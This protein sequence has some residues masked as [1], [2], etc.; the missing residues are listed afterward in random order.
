MAEARRRALEH[1]G[2]SSSTRSSSSARSSC[3]RSS[4]RRPR[5]ARRSGRVAPRTSGRVRADRRA[6]ACRGVADRR[7]P[8]AAVGA[9]ARSSGSRLLALGVARTASRARRRSSRFADRGRRCAARGAR[10]ACGR[11]ARA[12]RRNQPRRP[13]RDGSRPQ[14]RRLARRRSGHARP[15]IPAH[16]SRLRRARAPAARPSAWGGVVA[17]LGAR[18]RRAA[19]R[20][21]GP[22]ACRAIWVPADV[23]VAVGRHPRG[24]GPRGGLCAAR[25]RAAGL[26][27][28]VRPSARRSGDADARLALRVE[29]RLGSRARPAAEARRRRARSCRA[30]ADGTVPRRGRAGPT[31]CRRGQVQAQVEI[32]PSEG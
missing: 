31:R 24:D 16:A 11:R 10:A 19:A 6:S 30:F 2:S 32:Y 15:R 8:A 1:S 29:V 27:A 28:R 25:P 5:G 23:G 9:L 12:A 13:R 26:P 14:D 21:R 4:G 7:P 20:A 22:A 3:R 18:P 17:R